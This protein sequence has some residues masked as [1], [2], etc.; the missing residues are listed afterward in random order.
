VKFAFLIKWLVETMKVD[1]GKVLKRFFAGNPY[2]E[3]QKFD[4]LN[5]IIIRVQVFSI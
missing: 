3:S 5:A 4:E 1:I 2:S